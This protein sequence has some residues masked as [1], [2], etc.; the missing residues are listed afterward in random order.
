MIL[1]LGSGLSLGAMN[2]SGLKW[3]AGL[4]IQRKS[5]LKTYSE[6]DDSSG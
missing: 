2:G 6:L 4:F 1:F 5:V 3:E